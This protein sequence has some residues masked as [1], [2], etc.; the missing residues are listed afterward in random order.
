[1]SGSFSA[2]H[3]ISQKES[4]TRIS[5]S[6]CPNSKS[7]YSL[8]KNCFLN[9]SPITVNSLTVSCTTP[10]PVA[11]PLTHSLPHSHGLAH[12]AYWGTTCKWKRNKEG[13][14]KRK[15]GKHR[16][17]E[18]KNGKE[19][20]SFNW[21]IYWGPSALFFH[22]DNL[23]HALLFFQLHYY[24]WL[25]ICLL[26]PVHHSLISQNCSIS[27]VMVCCCSLSHS[28]LSD[29][30]W[31][32]ELQHTRLPCPSL[33]PWACSNS[34]PWSRWCHPTISSSIIPFSSCLQSVPASGSFSKES[35]VCIR[36]PK[37]WSFSFSTSAMDIQGWFPLGLT[38]LISLLSKVL[39]RV[40]QH[41]S[42]KASIL[43]HSA[44]FMFQ[45]SHL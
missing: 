45:L 42:W 19:V 7:F 37:S 39:S 27:I 35:A 4:L 28:F 3:W 16:Q 8:L 41:Y 30:L 32:H 1:M 25:L 10:E 6:I 43:W 36:W 24:N 12:N 9:F 5:K 18:K 44:F 20:V 13:M 15:K 29:L 33:S 23:G 34:C 22:I 21:G 26:P 2:L 38:D 17:G 11:F 31:S 14:K 40:F